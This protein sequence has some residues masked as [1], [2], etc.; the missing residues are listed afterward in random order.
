MTR[1]HQIENELA[2]LEL[3]RKELIEEKQQLLARAITRQAT[4]SPEEKIQ[5]FLA[6]FACRQDVYP[7]LWENAKDGRKGYS[8]VCANEWS[9]LVCEKPRI[10]CSDCMHQAFLPLNEAAARDHLTGKSVIGTYAIRKDHKCVFLAA[11]FDEGHWQQDCL[12]YKQATE[13]HGIAVGI[14]RSRS[15]NGGHAWIFFSEPIPAVLARRLGT[16]LLSAAQSLNPYLSLNSYDRLFPNQD[17]L[18]PGGFGNLI[19]LPLQEKA[20]K[21][22]NSVFVDDEMIP[23]EDQWQHLATLPLCTPELVE[24]IVSRVYASTCDDPSATFEDKS[25]DAI[26]NGLQ[27]G[28][29]GGVVK[30]ELGKQLEIDLGELPRVLIA[31][32]KRLGTISNPV[33]Y[34]KQRLRFPTY[35]IPRLIFCGELHADRI[36]LPRGVVEKAKA[37]VLSAGASWN[38]DDIRRHGNI[39]EYQFVGD[40]FSHQQEAV[41]AMLV[42]DHGVLLAPPGAGKTVMACAMITARKSRTLILVHRKPLMEQW[43][44]RIGQFL[45]LE[46]KRIGVWGTKKCNSDQP[47]VIAMMQG[48]MRSDSPVKIFNDFD[49]VIIDECHHVPA[50][51]FEAILKECSSRFILGLTATP[52]RKDGLQK[53]L[54]LQCGPIRHEL[55]QN[56]GDQPPRYLH[57][58]HLKMNWH[59][60]SPLMLQEIWDR[61]IRDED[62]NELIMR[63]ALQNLTDHRS[64]A[65]LSDR[66]EHLEI[67]SE[68][69]HRNLISSDQIFHLTGALGAKWR[70]IEMEKIQQA[71]A[72]GK[73]FL[74]LATSSLIGEGFDI[75]SLDTLMLA[76]P[77]SFRGRL[78][79]YAGRI[80]RQHEGKLYSRIFDYTE[81]DIPVSISMFRKRLQAYRT[82]GYQLVES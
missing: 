15:G 20:R 34:E 44:A 73:G 17:Q 66:K 25:L 60:E 76:M 47:I 71:I 11:D 21:L 35:M 50:A 75:P 1:M 43:I 52:Q 80:H 49:H 79:Q 22:G 16:V 30:A 13:R 18:A 74:L 81:D 36:V 69:L 27:K 45:G 65:L 54:F 67:L 5:L 26:S 51:S 28:V 48:I 40:L 33:F 14:E 59:D 77:I 7:R 72:E 12:A 57:V 6:R 61:L 9:K 58:R 4:F 68:M 82:M 23:Y 55:K 42:H 37:L 38:C 56:E 41:D 53:I 78:I 3:R 10:K 2:A 46:K 8:P 39:I 63:D 29:F 19:A 32:L 64:C 70:R 31:A 24:S 62:R